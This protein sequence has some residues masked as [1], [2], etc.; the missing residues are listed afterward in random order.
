MKISEKKRLIGILLIPIVMISM[1]L[2]HMQ[3]V[4][5]AG[6]YGLPQKK[7]LYNSNGIII[8]STG[9]VLYESGFFHVEFFAENNTNRDLC[10]QSRDL[11][12][13][14]YMMSWSD[15]CSTDIASGK[16]GSVWMNIDEANIVRNNI[17]TIES[18]E[19]K[20]LIFNWDD[21]SDTIESSVIT[22]PF[23]S[24]TH[25]HEFGD[26]I[27]ISEP[28]TY[29]T[30][31]K[32]RTCTVCGYTETETI[33]KVE[34][35]TS[36]Q[37]LHL[38]NPY[39][40]EHFYTSDVIESEALKKSGWNY[41][42]VAWKSPQ[43]SK[44]PVYR[45]FNPYSGEHHYTV[46]VGEKDYLATVGWNYE[47]IG[48]YSDDSQGI[49]LYRLYNPNATG[50]YAPGAHHYTKDMNEVNYLTTVGWKYEGIGWY[51]L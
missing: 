38:Y 3:P 16:K 24:D 25:I 41:E 45:L 33:P 15:S 40:G 43:S 36:K 12:I 46:D 30:G 35:D 29:S 14:G 32:T 22:L 10:I 18:M 37:M 17:S 21:S 9:N 44:T 48:W 19:F 8:K 4:L 1:L 42:G 39:S 47:G 49:P 50:Q 27:V 6:N 26:W 51:G 23:E 20:F 2:V 31:T 13:N 7:T 5:A 11:S 34:P 28:T